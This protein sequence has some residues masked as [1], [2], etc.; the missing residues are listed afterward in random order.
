MSQSLE[1]SKT[2]TILPLSASTSHS[3]VA[4]RVI[5]HSETACL[6]LG[7]Q[8]CEATEAKSARADQL[9]VFAHEILAKPAW[10]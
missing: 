8:P 10:V 1:N 2:F 9:E 3:A 7:H 5:L 4:L 6:N